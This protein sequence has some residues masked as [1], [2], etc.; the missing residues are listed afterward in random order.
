MTKKKTPKHKRKPKHSY[1]YW[2]KRFIK[3][4]GKELHDELL[5]D[6]VELRTSPQYW[7]PLVK[8]APM[9]MP[10]YLKNLIDRFFE[11][12]DEEAQQ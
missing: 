4:Q 9:P 7:E 6:V 1:Q 10:S 8:L 12:P 2:E 5:K 11:I 3:E